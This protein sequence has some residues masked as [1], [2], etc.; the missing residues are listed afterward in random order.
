MAKNTENN[1]FLA[2]RFTSFMRTAR[3]YLAR[4]IYRSCTVVLL[5]LLGLF[6]FFA[7]IDELDAL[8]ENFTLVSLMYLQALALPTR[9]Y[10]L[11]PIGLLIGAILALAGLAQR[12]EL[13]ILRVSGVSGM[14]LLRL[15][16]VATLPLVAVALLLSEYVT[17]MAEI[18]SGEANLLLRGRAEG[19][20]MA[21]EMP[22]WQVICWGLVV[23]APLTFPATAW[24]L[25]ATGPSWTAGSL[26]GFGYVSV[27]SM[28]L[29][30]F[31]WYAGLAGAGIAR[32]GQI[33][34]AQPLLTVC[35]AALL[36]GE[37]LDAATGLAALG[38]LV[39][40][41]WAQRA[42]GA[43]EERS[44]SPRRAVPV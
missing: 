11:L 35:W 17:P 5:A 25:A 39:C 9:L 7:L 2:V 19:G 6:T 24:L 34:L 16:W 41:A 12:N 14:K 42:R 37:R 15:L 20:R 30:F 32:G 1:G 27:F 3:R 36:L 44:P 23:C 18:K 22:A 38:V 4:E 13:V 28:F 43:G 31:A 40:V 8:G 10:D 26:A 33:Q 21:R 29:G